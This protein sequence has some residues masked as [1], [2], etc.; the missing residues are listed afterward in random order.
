MVFIRFVIAQF[1]F[2]YLLK[3]IYKY[4]NLKNK[5]EEKKFNKISF[6]ISFAIS[7]IVVGALEF[8]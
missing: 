3:L 7:Y 8:I 5:I 2:V 4:T 6:S 1:I